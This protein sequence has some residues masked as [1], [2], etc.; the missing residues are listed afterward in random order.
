MGARDVVI[1]SALPG[2][3]SVD[4]EKISHAYDHERERE[5]ET[6]RERECVNQRER[7]RAREREPISQLQ[8]LFDTIVVGRESA[9]AREREVFNVK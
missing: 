5:R 7:E 2:A 3:A 8:S 1:D 9:H 6:E 4:V